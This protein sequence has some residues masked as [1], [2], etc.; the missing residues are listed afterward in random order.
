[1][2]DGNLYQVAV[3]TKLHQLRAT[4]ERYF[5]PTQLMQCNL[6]ISLITLHTALCSVY[7]CH[8]NQVAGV[9]LNVI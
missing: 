9:Q 3:I 6:I 5:F 7:A 1:M 4:R 8:P 2:V